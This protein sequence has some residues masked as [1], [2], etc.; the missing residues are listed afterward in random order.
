MSMIMNI[1]SSLKPDEKIKK[2]IIKT[3]KDDSAD[4]YWSVGKS[5]TIKIVRRNGRFVSWHVLHV[6]IED[7]MGHR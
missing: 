7:A 6:S 3:K 4:M 2:T 5:K 1:L